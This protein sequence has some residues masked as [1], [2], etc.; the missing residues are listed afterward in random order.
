MHAG[1]DQEVDELAQFGLVDVAPAIA[2]RGHGESKVVAPVYSSGFPEGIAARGNKTAQ[3][4][5]PNE[6]TGTSQNGV[7]TAGVKQTRKAARLGPL[8]KR[9]SLHLWMH[10]DAGSDSSSS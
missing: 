10:R 3:V 2:R 5:L 6:R 9:A 1:V 7:A 8:R 4:H